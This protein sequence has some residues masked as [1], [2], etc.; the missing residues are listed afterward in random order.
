M[1]GLRQD[2]RDQ[3][4]YTIDSVSTAEIDD[5]LAVEVIKEGDGKERLRYWIHIADADRWAP[6][7]SQLFELARRR[8]TSLYLPQC[9]IHMLPSRCVTFRL[10]VRVDANRVF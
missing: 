9:A 3:K 2:L 10:L 6:R 4:V 5:G 8:A 1:L 7:D